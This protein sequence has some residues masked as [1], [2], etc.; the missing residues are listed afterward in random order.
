MKH[1]IAYFLLCSFFTYAKGA[2]PKEK[3]LSAKAQSGESADLQGTVSLRPPSGWYRVQDSKKFPPHMQMMLV[4]KG[5]YK[6]PPSIY[7]CT[8]QYEGTLQ[9]YLRIVKEINRSQ[10]GEWKNLGMV[11]TSLGQASLSEATAVTQW[12]HM[13]MMHVI[14]SHEGTIYILTGSALK[15]EFPKFYKIFYETLCSIQINKAFDATL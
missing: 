13:R 12:G 3:T 9:D 5:S 15:E 10:G 6:V 11:P 8:E 14:L 1:F 2:M 4:A 7:L